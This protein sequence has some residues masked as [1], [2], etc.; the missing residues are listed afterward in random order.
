M[1][2]QMENEMAATM[3]R[4]IY[5][6]IFIGISPIRM[7]HQMDKD[8]VNEMETELYRFVMLY[9]CPLESM[10]FANQAASFARV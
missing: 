5:I 1:E 2:Y 6:Y 4:D 10:M 7:E 3:H 8:M 9:S